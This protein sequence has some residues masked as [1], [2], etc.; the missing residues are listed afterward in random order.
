MRRISFNLL[1]VDETFQKHA[2]FSECLEVVI[3]TL[4]SHPN[5]S[6][7]HFPI[8]GF[9]PTVGRL[10]RGLKP[11][12]FRRFPFSRWSFSPIRIRPDCEPF[13]WGGLLGWFELLYRRRL[14]KRPGFE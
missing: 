5:T 14:P 2:T 6:R 8:G 10:A 4:L 9:D 12:S 13:S 3:V 7:F 1:R 11:P